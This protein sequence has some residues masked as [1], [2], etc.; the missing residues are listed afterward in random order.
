[1]MDRQCLIEHFNAENDEIEDSERNK[2]I[3]RRTDH[4]SIQS[5][6]YG[7]NE[8]QVPITTNWYLHSTV[9]HNNKE[10]WES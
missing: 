2:K 1:M 8:Y 6:N 5:F 3:N 9:F 10:S 7:F 4:D